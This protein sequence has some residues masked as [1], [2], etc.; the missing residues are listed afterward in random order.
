MEK[1]VNSVQ[2]AGERNIRELK[3][4]L[5]AAGDRRPGSGASPVFRE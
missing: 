4:R 1:V 3:R 5:D 2:S